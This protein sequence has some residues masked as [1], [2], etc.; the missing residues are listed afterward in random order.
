MFIAGVSS[1]LEPPINDLWTVPGE[2]HL[3]AEWQAEDRAV[4]EKVDATRHYHLRQDQD[5]LQ[6]ILEDR[7]PL[8]N[9]EEG[10]KTVELFTAIYRSQRDK[11]PVKFPLDAEDGAQ[12][13]DGRDRP[14]LNQER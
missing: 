1:V 9:G 5:F 6:A 12:G 7:E 8:V 3:L 11:G 13:F 10:R 4:F 14:A 2:A